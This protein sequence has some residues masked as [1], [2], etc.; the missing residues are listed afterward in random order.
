MPSSKSYLTALNYFSK[1]QL[2]YYNIYNKCSINKAVNKSFYSIKALRKLLELKKKN[3]Y[4]N[5][6]ESIDA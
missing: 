1:I 3:T 5:F 6:L 2:I 4:F